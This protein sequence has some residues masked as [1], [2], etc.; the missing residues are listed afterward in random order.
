VAFF[1]NFVLA[2]FCSIDIISLGLV[3]DTEQQIRTIK[4][5]D[6]TE[7]NIFELAYGESDQTT[8]RN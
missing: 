3:W 4:G 8:L 6:I 2:G 7:D 5:E 1:G